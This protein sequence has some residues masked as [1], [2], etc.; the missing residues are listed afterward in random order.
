MKRN[1]EVM[2]LGY[3]KEGMEYSGK[4]ILPM[5]G[6]IFGLAGIISSIIVMFI[7]GSF[8]AFICAALFGWLC[9]AS[10]KKFK[11]IQKR[12]SL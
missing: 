12:Y 3:N 4:I 1:K 6:T 5:F 10:W 8:T 7:Y 9:Y 2:V 11:A